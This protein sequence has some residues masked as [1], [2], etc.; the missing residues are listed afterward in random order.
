[1]AIMIV[2]QL[3]CDYYHIWEGSIELGCDGLAALNKTFTMVYL[4]DTDESN[5]D[6]LMVIRTLW[7]RSPL[8]WKI[9]HVKG[10]QDDDQDYESLDRWARLNIEMDKIQRN[11]S[12]SLKDSL[13]NIWFPLNLGQYG[14]IV[15]S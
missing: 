7:N 13:V 5:Q 15:K 14:L 11:L 10:H 12:L 2:A 4:I 1:L 6:L 9:R 3:L 8:P